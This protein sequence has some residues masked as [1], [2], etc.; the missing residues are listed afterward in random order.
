MQH[1]GVPLPHRFL[2][3]APANAPNIAGFGTHPIPAGPIDAVALGWPQDG[4]PPPPFPITLLPNVPNDYYRFRH[5][6]R[7]SFYTDPAS[8]TDTA[9]SVQES[10]RA[11]PEGL[12]IRQSV[13]FWPNLLAWSHPATGGIN[14][15]HT[16]N[17]W[18]GLAGNEHLYMLAEPGNLQVQRAACRLAARALESRYTND[19]DLEVNGEPSMQVQIQKQILSVVQDMLYV[20]SIVSAT[21]HY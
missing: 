3:P 16:L 4:N 13:T 2:A 9:S 5:P 8:H 6:P 21:S 7:A 15:N 12:E 10:L 19:Q 20:R 17:Y 14:G 18:D 11:L 1:I